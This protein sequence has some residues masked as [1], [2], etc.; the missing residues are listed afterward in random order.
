MGMASIDRAPGGGGVP[1]TVEVT[2]TCTYGGIHC[3]YANADGTTT[4]LTLSPSAPNVLIVKADSA[5]LLHTDGSPSRFTISTSP[6]VKPVSRAWDLE[7]SYTFP[8][9]APGENNNTMTVVLT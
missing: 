7:F 8:V 9:Y 6:T 3:L 5:V 1:E 2:I 4:Y